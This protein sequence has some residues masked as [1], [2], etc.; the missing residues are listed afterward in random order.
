MRTLVRLCLVLA[1]IAA[2]NCDA[3][4]QSELQQALK[5]VNI[6]PHWIYDDLPKALAQ[7]KATGKPILIVLRCVPCPPGRKLDAVVMQPDKDLEALEQQFV[8]V[9]IVQTRG[10]DLRTF[11]YDYDQSWCAMFMNADQVIY[12]RYG[13]RT[14]SG[15]NSDQLLTLPSF[16]KAMERALQL[17]K[18]YPGNKDALAGNIGKAPEYRVPEEIPGLQDLAK[19]PTIPK[20]CI[21]CHMVREYILRAKWE[22]RKLSLADLWVYPMPTQIGL[23][24]DI[25]DGLRVTTVTPDSPAGKAG[26]TAGD[27]IVRLNGQPLTSLADIQW[28]LHNSPDEAQ[29]KV[30]VR[31]GNETLEKTVALSGNWKETD[32]GWRASSWYGL[33]HGLKLDPLTAADKQKRGIPADGLALVVKNMYGKATA[34]LQKAGLRLG[35]VIVAVDG[36][37]R[38]LTES[39]FITAVRLKHGPGDSI[40]LSIIRGDARQEL[41]VPMW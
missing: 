34:T 30:T 1:A 21:H 3:P 25:D 15:P 33:R 19:G 35:D 6:A 8:C 11:Q 10:L 22:N 14:T 13:T 27:E 4:G 9:R 37:G 12:G 16:R 17:H 20:T 18:E 38:E 24:M 39:Q 41:T 40:R 7:A 5:D 26:L 2:V 23:T 36:T 28:V 32:I 31:R 29:L